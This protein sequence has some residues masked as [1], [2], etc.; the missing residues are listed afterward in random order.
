[1]STFKITQDIGNADIFLYPDGNST[2]SMTPVGAGTNYIC[3]KDDR[4]N[5]DDDITYVYTT[6]ATEVYDLYTIDDVVDD[7]ILDSEINYVQIVA[8]GKSHLI[9]QHP[10]GIYKIL[11]SDKVNNISSSDNKNLTTSYHT[12]SWLLNSVPS[13]LSDWAW[14]KINNMKIGVKCNSPTTFGDVLTS[15]P[16]RPNAGGDITQLKAYYGGSTH[17]PNPD[18]NY[19][20]VDDVTSDDMTTH[21]YTTALGWKYDLYNFPNH[22]TETGVIQKI[23]FVMK[24]YLQDVPL[25]GSSIRVAYKTGGITYNTPNV[26][27]PHDGNWHYYY[28]EVAENPNTA[29]AWTWS[30]I[31]SLQ[32]GFAVNSGSIYGR[33]TQFYFIVYY[34]TSSYNSE[35]RTTQT[36]CKV[37]FD[38]SPVECTL[39]TPYEYTFNHTYE[40]PTFNT[41]RGDRIVYDLQRKNKTV[42]M[43][44]KQWCTGGEYSE[45]ILECVHDMKDNGVYVVF[46]GFDDPNL[47]QG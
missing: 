40:V 9:S 29:T 4:N 27:L 41:W 43:H 30:D 5:P 22:T 13:D 34:Y 26:P 12:Y 15:N 39:N 18:V 37:N 35:I 1:M 23:V 36:Y 10:S 47:N 21:V 14:D 46:S 11:V 7:D 3:T 28:A 38:I 2:V 20:Q 8:R 16:Y 33:C 6:S 42:T 17:D 24:C 31:D 25:G 44:G 19:Q 32:A 45:E